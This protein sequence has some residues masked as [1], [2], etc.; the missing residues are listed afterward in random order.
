MFL[1]EFQGSTLNLI[2]LSFIVCKAAFNGWR[3]D[4]RLYVNVESTVDTERFRLSSTIIASIES[5]EDLPMTEAARRYEAELTLSVAGYPRRGKESFT[6][7]TRGAEGLEI[8]GVYG[9]CDILQQNESGV[10]CG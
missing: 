10:A 2:E 6:A 5:R 7:N 3:R 8:L 9:S 1:I 4:P